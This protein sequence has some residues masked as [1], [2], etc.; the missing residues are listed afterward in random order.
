MVCFYKCCRISIKFNK[1]NFE[2]TSKD[3]LKCLGGYFLHPVLE[4][5]LLALKCY[6]HSKYVFKCSNK[7]WRNLQGASGLP[8]TI[9]CLYNNNN[10]TIGIQLPAL[11]QLETFSYQTFTSP[12]TEML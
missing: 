7:C 4:E 9:P 3:T 5:P 12:L 6:C 10:N 11:Q 1:H 8:E 2:N